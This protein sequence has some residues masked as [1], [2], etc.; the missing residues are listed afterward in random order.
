M[1]GVKIMGLESRVRK[2]LQGC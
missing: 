2:S 1:S